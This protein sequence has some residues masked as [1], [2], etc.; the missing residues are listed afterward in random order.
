MKTFFAALL[1]LVNII[2]KPAGRVAYGFAITSLDRMFS[3]KANCDDRS[4]SARRRTMLNFFVD[5]YS[6]R[7]LLFDICSFGKVGV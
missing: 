6:V 1:E 4:S 3:M 7:Y 2:N 5:Q